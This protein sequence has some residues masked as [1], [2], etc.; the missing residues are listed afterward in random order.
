MRRRR[1]GRP[2]GPGS[3][4]DHG[5]PAEPRRSRHRAPGA[6]PGRR[7]G[8]PVAPTAPVGASAIRCAASQPASTSVVAQPGCSRG[9]AEPVRLQCREDGRFVGADGSSC[10]H[11]F[12]QR[13]SLGRCLG[14]DGGRS[15]GRERTASGGT[16]AIGASSASGSGSGAAAS[17][18]GSG[19]GSGD[20][21]GL[22]LCRRL[23]Y[24]GDRLRLG[25]GAPARPRPRRPARPLGSAGLRQPGQGVDGGEVARGRLLLGR[26]GADHLGPG[27]R[28]RCERRRRRGRRAATTGS[29]T[30]VSA[31]T[32]V[33]SATGTGSQDS[34]GSG[35][36]TVLP[37]SRAGGSA[38]R[39]VTP[40]RSLS[41]RRTWMPR[42]RASRLTT[43]RPIRRAVSALISPPEE[44][45]A[46]SRVSSLVDT[47]RPASAISTST[48]SAVRTAS[49]MTGAV[50]GE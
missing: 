42:R 38:I 29:S 17:G 36:T 19:S 30:Y 48:P 41:S 20:C 13:L 28:R 31:T 26:L 39:A 12:V 8:S 49:T 7:T 47:P 3:P 43:S 15:P 33:G 37:G 18:S 50:G 45:S 2:A 4:R 5:R 40:P 11:R 16:T 44:S 23:R 27:G 10:G 6:D 1:R 14:S 32:G 46:L 25:G 21:L 24:D 34:T 35:V 22:G 9:G